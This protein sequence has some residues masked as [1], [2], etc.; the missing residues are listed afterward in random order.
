MK[1]SI[2]KLEEDIGT[3]LDHAPV[4]DVLAILTGAF[5]GLTVELVRRQGHDPEERITINGGTSRDIT[6]HAA[7]GHRTPHCPDVLLRQ[8]REALTKAR[9]DLLDSS[10]PVA[11]IDRLLALMQTQ[12]G[13]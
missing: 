1:S 13:A 9:L 7:E 5:V 2:E 6:I 4:A 12:A 10:R 3:A 8:C 11:Y